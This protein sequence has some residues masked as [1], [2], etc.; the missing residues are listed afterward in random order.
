MYIFILAGVVFS[1]VKIIFG[2]EVVVDAVNAGC[3]ILN[4]MICKEWKEFT[5]LVKND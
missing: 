5:E 1:R 2:I 3:T 4:Q